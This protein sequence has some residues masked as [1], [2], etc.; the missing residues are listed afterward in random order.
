MLCYP[1]RAEMAEF[2]GETCPFG[3][4]ASRSGKRSADELSKMEYT[5]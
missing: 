5:I 3:Q 2:S 4:F 1:T